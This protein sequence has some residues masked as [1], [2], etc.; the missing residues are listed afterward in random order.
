MSLELDRSI[1][2]AL[3][4]VNECNGQNY[5]ETL[6]SSLAVLL[7]ADYVLAA[8]IDLAH[9]RAD[10]VALWHQGGVGDKLSYDLEGTPCE[11]VFSDG[12]CCYPRDIATLFPKDR[13]LTELDLEGYVGRSLKDSQG[14]PIGLLVALFKQRDHARETILSIFDLFALRAGAELERAQLVQKLQAQITQLKET[15]E[16]LELA[17]RVFQHTNE[18]M[19]ISDDNNCILDV[20]SAFEQMCGYPKAE[21]IGNNPSILSSGLQTGTFYQEMWQQLLD[22]NHWQGELWNRRK[23]GSTYPVWSSISLVKDDT[24]KTTHHISSCKDISSELALQ[25]QLYQQATQDYLTGLS[26][27]FEFHDHASKVISTARRSSDNFALVRLN[28]DN[29][30]LV[31]SS[32]G[33]V[34]G[35]RL[36]KAVGNR[37]KEYSSDNDILSRLGGDDFA[38]LLGYATFKEL[39]EKL[40]QTL[41][42]IQATVATG[43]GDITASCS[44]GVSILGDDAQGLNS[45]MKNAYRALRHAKEHNRGRYCFYSLEHENL[46]R[47]NDSIENSLYKAVAEKVIEPHFQP[48]VSLS[49]MKVHHFEALARWY[50]ESLGQVSPMEFIPIAE[51]TGLIKQIGEQILG[52]AAETITELNER[53]ER[54]IGVTVNRSPREFNFGDN[55][56]N[57]AGR[58]LERLGLHAE[59]ICIEITESLMLELPDQ[60]LTHLQKLK[61]QGFCLALDDFGTGFSSLSYLKHYPF[62]FLKIDQSFVKDMNAQSDD[63]I[64]VK[65]IIQMAQNL[66][67]ETIAEGVETEEQC[68]MLIDLGC[69]YGQGYYFSKPLPKDQLFDFVT[70]RQN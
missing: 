8:E 53:L 11:A 68:Q 24:G 26:N 23:D 25:E 67:L 55:E 46:A 34:M 43:S 14:K 17:K 61:E 30:T 69:D 44:A 31:N 49:D 70:A 45:L 52:K 36:V 57:S 33:Y 62:D 16:Q 21:L 41:H 50:D 4:E 12:I 63:Y 65:T 56:D 39:E 27:S 18:G 32:Y 5:F 10:T 6:V 51:S 19:L 1:D 47:R 9:Q 3:K 59:H 2:R 66:G 37:L 20:N 38:I 60:A 7:D 35:D 48:V 40:K 13:M 64:L 29:L 54:P 28:I 15:N 22:S 58:V 42:L